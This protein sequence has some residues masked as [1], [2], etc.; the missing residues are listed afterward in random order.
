MQRARVASEIVPVAELEAGA[1]DAMFALFARHYDCVDAARFRGDLADKVAVI[2]LRDAA[3]GALAGFST[4]AVMQAPAAA[5]RSVRQ[6]H[7]PETPARS[8]SS[9][10]HGA[11]RPI[12]ALF[13][14]DTIID[15]PYWGSQELTRAWCRFAGELK[16]SCEETPLYWFLI[17]K[18]YRTYLFL[19]IY[20][21][22]FYPRFD[23]PTPEPEQRILDAL[24]GARFPA[25]YRPST[26]TVQF[27][28]SHGQLTAELAEI[29]PHHRENPHVRFFLQRNPG[30]AGGHELV[31][32]AE[33]A[34]QNMRGLAAR[35][36]R[37]AC[38]QAAEQPLKSDVQSAQGAAAPFPSSR[39][40]PPPRSVVRLSR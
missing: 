29:A 12:R 40:H 10:P 19:P 15:R 21:R 27:A 8:E 23:R 11:G 9:T 4:L 38:G 20:F 5:L 16:R 25:D 39:K 37:E 33:I 18:G 13:S 35:I 6:A 34:P 36:M 17:S 30:F 28:D 32:L 26:G 22:E 3:S 31:C 1:V 2:L 7:S 14:G 24:A